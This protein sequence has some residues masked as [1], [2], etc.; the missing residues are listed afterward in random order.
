MKCEKYTSFL[1]PNILWFIMNLFSYTIQADTE[2]DILTRY[3]TTS[4]VSRVFYNLPAVGYIRPRFNHFQRSTAFWDKNGRFLKS[5][6]CGAF[7]IFSS[8]MRKFIWV[9]ITPYFFA[10]LQINRWDISEGNENKVH[11]IFYVIIGTYF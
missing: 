10:L 6:L 2:K 7:C 9:I 11:L 4:S 8:I 3:S 1:C 5:H